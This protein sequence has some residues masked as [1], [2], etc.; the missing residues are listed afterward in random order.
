LLVSAPRDHNGSLF[1]RLFQEGLSLHRSGRYRA[2]LHLY[3]QALAFDPQDPRLWNNIGAVRRALGEFQPA[4]EALT[5]AIEL[6]PRYSA[7]WVNLGVVLEALGERQEAALAFQTAL[8]LDP[9]NPSASV[10][11]AIQ[12][13][14]AGLWEEA[15]RLLEEALRR[16]PLIPEA[17]YE[18]GRLSEA[19]GDRDKA[20]LHYRR[21]LEL[22]AARFP[23]IA[24][25]VRARLD[26]LS[27]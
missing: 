21:F 24:T 16:D 23:E 2:A 9:G 15:Q 20:T 22:G 18:L 1:D 11:L 4:R 5:R 7:A 13:H 3:E 19:R 25:Q 12:Y 27:P 26:R 14:Q 6:D 10:N 8:G 17:H